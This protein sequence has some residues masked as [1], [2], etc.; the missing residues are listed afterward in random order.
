MSKARKIFLIRLVLFLMFALV[1]PI[2]FV[3]DRYELFENINEFKF[4]M[5]GMVVLII[6]IAVGL[7]ILSV[8]QKAMP[9]SMFTQVFNGLLKIT[10]PLVALW[11][12]LNKIQN[13]FN[14]FNQCLLCIIISETIAIPINPFPKWIGE[15]SRR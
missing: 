6:V 14:L 4:T 1:I 7:Y 3:A 11:L 13:T 12:V 15:R 8:I 10:L 2:I 5:W 9:Y